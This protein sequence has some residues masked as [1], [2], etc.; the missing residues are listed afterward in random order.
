[1]KTHALTIL[2]TLFLASSCLKYEQDA[3]VEQ[4]VISA[5]LVAGELFPR[6]DY[7]RTVPINM[8]YDPAATAVSGATVR[9][10][11]VDAT[12]AV[13]NAIPYQQESP[14]V[15][16]PSDAVTR[17]KPLARYKLEASVPGGTGLITG[18]TLVPD[19]FTVRTLNSTVLP[20]QGAE[21]FR[22]NLS[23]SVYPGRQTYYVITTTAL[24]TTQGLTPFYANFAREA[25]QD[26][27]V[28]SSGI[29][30][31]QNYVALPDGSIELKYPWLALAYYG[32]N[33]IT[34]HAID[35]NLYDFVRSAS[36]QL[37]GSTTSPGEIE[38]VISRLDGAIGVFGS[39]AAAS[40]TVTVTR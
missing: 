13:L 37:G 36:V 16:R 32:P 19:T 6:L 8:A 7:T 15:Y 3:Y 40:T 11:E 14:G 18:Y 4:Y 1:M 25:N 33:R 35:D 34:F 20:Y 24:D 29:I 5:Y 12:G 31:A 28:T 17:V 38:N 22:A 30:N 23:P 9:I 26:V 39:M 21:Q 10:L 2:A 27:S